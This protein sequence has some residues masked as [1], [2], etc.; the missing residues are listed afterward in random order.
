MLFLNSYSNYLLILA[1][2]DVWL[3]YATKSRGGEKFLGN[4]GIATLTLTLTPYKSPFS[5]LSAPRK[6]PNESNQPESS[7]ESNRIESSSNQ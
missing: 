2:P 7:N 4:T 1:R 3:S 5:Y 6:A